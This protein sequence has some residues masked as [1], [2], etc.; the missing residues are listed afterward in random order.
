MRAF[1]TGA[2]GFI[3]GHVAR[4]LRE[5][6]DEVVAL[7]RAPERAAPLGD[8]GCRLVEGTLSSEPVIR[9]A[10]SGA[11]AVFHVAAIYKVGIPRSARPE[12]YDANVIGT[13]R[14]LD[15]A[16]AAG[17]PRIVHV[18]TI[19]V[20]GNTRGRVVDETYRRDEADG[21]LTYYDETK[22]L[23]HRVAEDRIAA[24]APVVIVQPGGVYGPNDPS[25]LGNLIGRVRAGKLPFKAYP[26]TGFNFVH[27]GDAATGILLCHDRASLG[28]SYV[29]GGEL[30]TL[31]A[32]IDAVARL[33]GRKPPRIT[34]PPF[35]L[36][37]GIP[38]GPLVGRFLGLQP[39]L[40]ELI[41]AAEGVTYWATDEKAR[42]ELGYSP[43]DLET[44]L[45][46]TLSARADVLRSSDASR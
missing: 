16:I 10:V 43:R 4:R 5:R 39:N 28:Q 2:T 26:E 44:G 24:G 7:V 15:A 35:L 34:V 46:Q 29:L 8:I 1:V 6:G 42:R 45:R 22:Y 31:G 3:G 27:I 21:F 9:D 19:N 20:F 37:L 12:M 25:D 18:S 23:A 17:V 40:R 38:F 33:A 41:R 30:S 32:F 14:V 11:D 13:Q 36:K